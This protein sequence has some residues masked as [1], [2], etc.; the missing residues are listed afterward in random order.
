M[1]F[2]V[3]FIPAKRTFGTL[4]GGLDAGDFILKRKQSICCCK[5]PCLLPSID[6][7]LLNNNLIKKMDLKDAN[8]LQSIY[9]ISSPVAPTTINPSSLFYLNYNIDPNGLLFGNSPCGINNYPY[10][11]VYK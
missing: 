4:K 11:M 3:P 2:R 1:T 8:I 7:T 5:D 10:F 9:P 6:P